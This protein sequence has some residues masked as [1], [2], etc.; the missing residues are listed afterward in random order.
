[1]M[2]LMDDHQTTQIIYLFHIPSLRG[3]PHVR[4]RM[5]MIGLFFRTWLC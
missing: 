2:P 4:C 3:K 1:M 5:P